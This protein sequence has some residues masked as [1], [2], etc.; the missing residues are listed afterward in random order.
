MKSKLFFIIAILASASAFASNGGDINGAGCTNNCGNGGGQGGA[1]GNGG[2]STSV[3]GSS[4]AAAAISGAISVSSSNASANPVSIAGGGDATGGTATASGNG[5]SASTGSVT[6]S[7]TT[8]NVRSLS[9][10]AAA[11]GSPAN[12]TCVA[13]FA[14]AFGLITA[15][16][17]LDSCLAVQQAI[18]LTHL[19]LRDAAIARLCQLDEIYATGVC[20]AKEKKAVIQQ[21]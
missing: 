18:L 9:L 19:G 2:Q 4:S 1:G 6:N 17:Q 8:G 20:Q 5:G 13:H 3:S 10:G 7:V 15:P 21:D 14:F 11:V 16:V 12:D